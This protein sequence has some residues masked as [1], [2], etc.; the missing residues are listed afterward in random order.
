MAT[1]VKR[2]SLD[3]A[4]VQQYLRSVALFYQRTS[5]V[6]FNKN[7]SCRSKT[8]AQHETHLRQVTAWCPRLRGVHERRERGGAERG[9]LVGST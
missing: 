2:L 6:R 9:G 3:A 8:T 1:H 7:L 5:G 4:A